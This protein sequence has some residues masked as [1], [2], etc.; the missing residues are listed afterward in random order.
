MD[1]VEFL[2]AALLTLAA[3]RDGGVLADIGAWFQGVGTGVQSVGVEAFRLTAS[4]LLVFGAVVV[5]ALS[6]RLAVRR[7]D[8]YSPPT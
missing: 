8:R 2:P 7:F 6:Y 5:A 3:G 1:V 4:G